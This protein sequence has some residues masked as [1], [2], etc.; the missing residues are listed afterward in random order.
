MVMNACNGTRTMKMNRCNGVRSMTMATPY[1]YGMPRNLLRTEA[2]L[3]R[4]ISLD[5]QGKAAIAR[6]AL[7]RGASS[8]L[9][10]VVRPSGQHKLKPMEAGKAVRTDKVFAKG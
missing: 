1:T 4:Y 5:R 7:R 2:V 6:G 8:R 9:T 10:R 3:R